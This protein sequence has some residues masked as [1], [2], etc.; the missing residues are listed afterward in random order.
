[1]F[2]R[3]TAQ[4]LL[5]RRGERDVVPALVDLASDHTVDELGLNVGVLHALWT[6]HGLGA[7]EAEGASEAE[8]DALRIARQAL[9][10]PAPSVRR[11]ALQVL[12]RDDRLLD[13]ILTAGI[14]PDRSSPTEVDYTVPTSV[15][16]DADPKVRL[17]A[18][19]A[20][21]ELPSSP[22]V[23]ATVGEILRSPVNLQD[24]WLP[25]AGAIAGARQG[26][27]FLLDLVADAPREDSTATAG[28][29][30]ATHLMAR[31]H[32]SDGDVEAAVSIVQA[33][34]AVA[35]PVGVAMVE[36]IGAGWPEGD[37]PSLTA[38]Q[39]TRLARASRMAPHLAD[40]LADLG[41][42]WGVPG[43]S[44]AS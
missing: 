20:V 24:P 1:M 16:Q 4:R 17:E 28:L 43:L 13:A 8:R 34:T 19:L 36:G 25:D 2:W 15:L 38:E 7:F 30:R 9:R 23:A 6:L 11:A 29:A 10:H 22:R 42:R 14:L 12:P 40:A 32:A 26:L 39:R 44:G 37:G 41:E 18:L 33:A 5:V 21:S 27:D 3:L 35:E 31:F